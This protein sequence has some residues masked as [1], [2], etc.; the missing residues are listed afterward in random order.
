M[1]AAKTLM[2]TGLMA[3]IIWG[4]KQEAVSNKVTESL[5]IRYVR[6][7]GV[8]QYL[9]KEEIKQALM[10][11]VTVSIFDADMQRIHAT[12]TQMP[13][14]KSATVERVWPD[15]I[16]IKVNERKAFVRW[17]KDGLLT[18]HGE[19][20][21]PSNVDQFNTLILIEG[22]KQQEAKT[23]EIM[24]GVKMALEDQAL[25]L[26]EF[27]VNNREAWEIKL[28]SGLEILL[29]RTGQLKKL[30]RF[31]QTLAI[32]GSEKMAAMQLVDCRYPNGFAVSWKP[33][34]E[35]IDWGIP[36]IEQ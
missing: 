16:D 28:K 2:V 24:K 27:K 29:G 21:M 19:L 36:K 3:L 33:D 18:E 25:E 11:L 13:W 30:E 7:E 35:P 15:A 26:A 10:P 17:G 14:V 9:S 20:F 8:F 4:M 12:V 32:F 23:L 22:P 6:T 31:L 5:P 1:Q 34:I